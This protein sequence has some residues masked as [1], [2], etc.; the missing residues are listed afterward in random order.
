M[1]FWLMESDY[2]TFEY[3][4]FTGLT[5]EPANVL[6]PYNNDETLEEYFENEYGLTLAYPELMCIW[7]WVDDNVSRFYPL[8]VVKLKNFDGPVFL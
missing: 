8:E 7:E 6:K 3:I 1:D 2:S 5:N 4:F